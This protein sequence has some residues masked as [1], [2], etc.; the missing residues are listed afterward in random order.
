MPKVPQVSD[1]DLLNTDGPT[2]ETNTD[3][4]GVNGVLGVKPPLLPQFTPE[5]H[6]TMPC[7][8]AGE[9]VN[10][11]TLYGEGFTPAEICYDL[12]GGT[13]DEARMQR[14]KQGFAALLDSL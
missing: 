5:R 9:P 11:N 13:L 1:F 8:D 3:E 7:Y 10:D 6:L 2:I 12:M 14:Q 4:A